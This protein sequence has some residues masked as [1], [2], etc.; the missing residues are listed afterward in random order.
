MASRRDVVVEQLHQL[1]DDFEELWKALT[2][3]PAAEQ[4][5]Q[6]GW[7]L[8]AGI[9][10]AG[11]TMASRHAVAKLWPILTGES[12]PT[13]KTPATPQPSRPAE[14]ETLSAER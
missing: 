14:K 3:D 13:Q 12:P 6:R 8:L 7:T 10:A 11:A 5:K 4:R 9:F 1:A 2:R